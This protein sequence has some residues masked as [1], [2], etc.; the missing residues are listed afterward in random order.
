[1]ALLRAAR[2]IEG[3]YLSTEIARESFILRDTLLL[4]V[5]TTK[6]TLKVQLVISVSQWGSKLLR[7]FGR[8]FLAL[9]FDHHG[10]H[11]VLRV[12]RNTS[13]RPVYQIH[14]CRPALSTE[15]CVHVVPTTCIKVIQGKTVTQPCGAHRVQSTVHPGSACVYCGVQ[16]RQVQVF[17]V[18]RSYGQVHGFAQVLRGVSFSKTE[19]CC[20]ALSKLAE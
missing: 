11:A 5:R 15:R 9:V 16:H 8:P 4:L 10:H 1:M 6:I 13:E 7:L 3:P 20:R 2:V 18:G 12:S 19:R 17:V 14:G